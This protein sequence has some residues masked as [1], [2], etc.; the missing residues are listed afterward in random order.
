MKWARSF[1][2]LAATLTVTACDAARTPPAGVPTRSAPAGF[3][4][5]P[6]EITLAF[7]GDVHFAGRTADLLGDPATAFGSISSTLPAAD[8]AMVNL[9]TA[10]TTR[11]APEPKEFHFQAPAGAYDAVKAAGIDVVSIANNH[12]LD[13]GRTGL[14]DTV[15]AART[16]GLPAV[17]AGADAAAAYRPWITEIRGT[18]IAVLGFSQVS[19]LW[20]EWKATD[21]RAGIALTRDLPR[22]VAAV[23]AARRQASVV[24]VYVHWGT[25][26][27]ACPPAEAR[28]FA[29]KMAEAGASI[30]V[31]THAHLLLGDGWLGK[32]FVQYG[33]GNFLWWRDDAYSNDTGVLRVTLAASA[34]SKTEL[35]PATISRRTGRPELADGEDTARIRQ[36]YAGLHAC[37]G[38]AASPAQ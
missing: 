5:P 37:T 25:E 14:A 33:L 4:S 24:V 34:I 10:V 9:E 26:G 29:D 6:A 27:K 30:V 1:V 11:G 36:K 31:G 8:L 18:R 21:T 13:Y 3:P 28:A 15:D 2:A 38:L 12:A 7:A 32:T 17:G 23:R 35:V 20:S 22:A 19:E 16:V